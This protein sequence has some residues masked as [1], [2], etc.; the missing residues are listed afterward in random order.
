MAKINEIKRKKASTEKTAQ[1]TRALELVSASKLGK[2]SEKKLKIE[3]YSH[4]LSKMIGHLA[5]S[6]KQ[7][8]INDYFTPHKKVKVVGIIVVSTDRGL[9]GNLNTQTFKKVLEFMQDLQ[10]QNKGVVIC[11]VGNKATSFFQKFNLQ[12][13][14]SCAKPD[15]S[16]KTV[17]ETCQKLIYQ[18]KQ[19]NV[20]E[21]YVFY[22]QMNSILEQVPV[23]KQILPIPKIPRENLTGLCEYIY[24]PNKKNILDTL[25]DRFIRYSIYQAVVENAASEEA[26]R[27]MAMKNATDNA[28][29]IIETL[30]LSVNKARQTQVT[31]ELSEIIGGAEAIE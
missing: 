14:E 23:K 7:D 19:K 25:L 18:Y 20:N 2:T 3:R 21:V 8:D 24:E 22:S 16:D 27:T 5:E 30:Q 1:I 29:K 26:A 9:C 4:L 17:L 15:I 13:L 10:N 28:G 12:V 6:C 31:T 11:T